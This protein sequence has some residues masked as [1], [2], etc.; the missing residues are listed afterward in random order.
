M[1]ITDLTDILANV[2]TVV[3]IFIALWFGK[4][5]LDDMTRSRKMAII[6]MIFKDWNN[7]D[8]Y[9]AYTFTLN[10]Q[11]PEWSKFKEQNPPGSPGWYKWMKTMNFFDTV[12][13]YLR[14]GAIDEEMAYAQLRTL[15]RL[16]EKVAHLAKG[17]QEDFNSPT[18]AEDFRKL[19]DSLTRNHPSTG[20]AP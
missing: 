5:Q 20:V 16:W 14:F 17:Y 4:K 9:E 7:L 19:Y 12:G 10:M 15:P 6:Q 8:M 3:A 2:A 11:F 13:S 18:F 1:K